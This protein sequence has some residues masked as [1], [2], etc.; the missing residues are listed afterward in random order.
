METILLPYT[1]FIDTLT[2][3]K[4]GL[5][6]SG[7]F[8]A[9][10]FQAVLLSMGTMH[11][12]FGHPAH[13]LVALTE[14]IQEAQQASDNSCLAHILAALCYLLLRLVLLATQ[15]A[16]IQLYLL[17]LKLEQGLHWQFSSSYL[18]SLEDVSTGQLT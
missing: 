4:E 17:G 7:A 16:L 3:G 14:A 8:S 6:N 10:R 1:V 13:A 15:E 5:D 18:Y 11:S 12:R 9:G 2:T